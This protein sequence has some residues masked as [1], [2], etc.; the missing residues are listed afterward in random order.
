MF[1]ILL[2]LNQLNMHSNKQVGHVDVNVEMFY[3][4]FKIDQNRCC[5]LVI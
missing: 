3:L 1:M 2:I 5:Q 4:K